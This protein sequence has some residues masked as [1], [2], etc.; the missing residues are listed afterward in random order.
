MALPVV[1]HV[2]DLLARD[3]DFMACYSG[4]LWTIKNPTPGT[5]IAGHTSLTRT[6]PLFSIYQTDLAANPA[7]ER[8]LTLT[9][10]TIS[11]VS[12]LAG[13]AITILVNVD[14]TNRY[15]SGGTTVTPQRTNASQALTPGFTVKSLPTLTADGSTDWD[16][17]EIQLP[18]VSP[19]FVTINFKGGIRIGKTGT[20]SV[21]AFAATTAP[22]LTFCASIIEG[23][24][25][26]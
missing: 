6:T 21:Y 15:S 13:G 8:P 20:L 19:S 4:E 18:A 1:G 14:N 24:A 7:T 25:E 10:L 26:I 11:Q 2:V 3:T 22:T 5:G 17:Y 9:S 16:A 12:T 23:G